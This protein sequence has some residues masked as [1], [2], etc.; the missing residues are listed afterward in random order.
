MSDVLAR[1]RLLV[2]GGEIEVSLHGARELAADAI[3]L[4][5]VVAGLD[6]ALALEEYPAFAKGPSV[7]VLEFDEQQ[8]PL[9]IVWGIPKD[10]ESPAVLITTY[11]PDPLRWSADF[12]RRPK[13]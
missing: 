8:K 11:R 10:R 1:I 4:D 2:G 3:L 5:D 12:M 13:P 7:L 6:A 9:H